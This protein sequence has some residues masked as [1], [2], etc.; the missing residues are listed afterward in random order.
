MSMRC[1][2]IR[3]LLI[4]SVLLGAC[5]AS[6]G[7]GGGD[8][9]TTKP[10]EVDRELLEREQWKRMQEFMEKKKQGQIPGQGPPPGAQGYGGQRR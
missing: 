8:A 7:C 4:A 10:V 2:S 9:D 1:A 5:L 3:G 6:P